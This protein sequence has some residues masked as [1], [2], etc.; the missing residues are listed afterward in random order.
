MT[1]QQHKVIK[2]W[3]ILD[4]RSEPAEVYA[5]T[6]LEDEHGQCAFVRQISE[7]PPP[8][9]PGTI[10]CRR[11]LNKARI[12]HTIELLPFGRLQREAMLD[13]A[14]ENVAYLRTK[15]CFCQEVTE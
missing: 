9:A 4:C 13:Y 3:I 11:K 15:F 12:R 14:E 5:Q 6:V 1:S 7:A 8:A 2:K 10:L